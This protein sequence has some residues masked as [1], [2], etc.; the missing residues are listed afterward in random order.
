MEA[1]INKV[2]GSVKNSYIVFDNG[3]QYTFVS[4]NQGIYRNKVKIAREVEN[5]TFE[6]KVKNGKSI[7]VVNIKMNSI[8]N[9]TIEYT[10]RN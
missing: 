8:S 4:E 7:V 1:K 9:K 5:C 2:D 10:L 3:V 6:Y